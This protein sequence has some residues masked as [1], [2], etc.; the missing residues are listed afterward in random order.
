MG[1]VED[2][3]M[4]EVDACGMFGE[5]LDIGNNDWSWQWVEESKYVGWKLC[6]NCEYLLSLHQQFAHLHVA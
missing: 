1:I 5:I 6:S 2:V 3:E 4:F